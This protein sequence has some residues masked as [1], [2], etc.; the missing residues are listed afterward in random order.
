VPNDVMARRTVTDALMAR[1]ETL[2]RLLA[3]WESL[4][5]TQDRVNAHT[6]QTLEAVLLRIDTLETWVNSR[7]DELARKEA[8]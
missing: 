3:A 2:E 6:V 8:R 1:I 7:F 5:Q 4:N